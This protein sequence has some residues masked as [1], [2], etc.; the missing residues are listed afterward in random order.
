VRSV[1]GDTHDRAPERRS[2]C[3][4]SNRALVATR[5]GVY[6]HHDDGV[7]VRRRFHKRRSQA[8]EPFNGWF[9]KVFEWR[10]PM[11]VKGLR[12]SPLS[13]LGAMVGYPLGLRYQHEHNLP[14]GKGMKPLLRAA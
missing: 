13:A 7:A 9:K 10:T 11:P 2:L 3:E 4:P 12:R 1:L 5:R 14:L 6:P 8:L